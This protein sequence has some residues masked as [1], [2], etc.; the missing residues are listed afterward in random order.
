MTKPSNST[1]GVSAWAPNTPSRPIG[2]LA[3]VS[4]KV[5]L[6]D[7]PDLATARLLEE[8]NADVRRQAGLA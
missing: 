8:L 6:I 5:I 1:P 4:G 3:G 2:R 7:G